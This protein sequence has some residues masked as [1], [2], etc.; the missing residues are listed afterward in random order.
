MWLSLGPLSQKLY[1]YL[2][3]LK[4][5]L[6]NSPS[7]HPSEKFGQVKNFFFATFCDKSNCGLCNWNDECAVSH[8]QE[9]RWWKCSYTLYRNM[10]M[11]D[12]PSKR[13][14]M[15]YS[16]VEIHSLHTDRRKEGECER[17]WWLST[18][19]TACGPLIS[20]LTILMS[21]HQPESARKRTHKQKCTLLWIWDFRSQINNMT[22]WLSSGSALCVVTYWT[23]HLYCFVFS[24]RFFSFYSQSIVLCMFV[25]TWMSGVCCTGVSIQL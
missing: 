25:Y 6:W 10:W 7:T 17:K 3:S 11:G 13:L 23:W 2:K 16:A 8:L 5:L 24:D 12:L 18:F 9:Y 1:S 20:P 15:Q 21:H 14:L 4:F 19:G 22:A